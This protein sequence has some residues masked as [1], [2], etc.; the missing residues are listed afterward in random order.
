[1]D[2]ILGLIAIGAVAYF[3]F[4]KKDQTDQPVTGQVV[5]PYKVEKPEEAPVIET[6]TAVAEVAPAKPKKAKAPAKPKAPKA[7]GEKKPRA[8]RKKKAA[9]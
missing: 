3:V 9:E 8:P 1:M 7:T 2:I 4:R 6:N 5:A